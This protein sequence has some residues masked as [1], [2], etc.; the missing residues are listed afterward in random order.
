MKVRCAQC[1]KWIEKETG[2]VN[3]AKKVGLKLFCDKHCFG[4]SRRRHKTKAQ[5]VAEKRLYDI[6]YRRKN[7][8]LLKAKKRAYFE[9]TYDPVA[10][11]KVRK[12]RMHLHVAYCRQP[13]YKRWKKRYDNRYR[14]G[15]MFGSYAESFLLL[16]KIER[17]VSSRM[18]KHEV[19][20]SNGIIN[21]AQ[22][23][24]RA[25]ARLIGSQSQGRTVGNLAGN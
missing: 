23:R 17:E 1:R 21:K 7:R 5:K 2:H 14:A 18:T 3:R 10:A 4:I 11:A 8:K 12:A 19:R 13:H 9:R 20:Q 22:E 24:K 6:E 15:K 16:Q 25:F